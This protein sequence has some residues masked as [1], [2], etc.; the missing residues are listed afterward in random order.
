MWILCN[1]LGIIGIVATSL[2]E[3]ED[4][5]VYGF[6]AKHDNDSA[7]P[8]HMCV[9]SALVSLLLMLLLFCVNAD[10]LRHVSNGHLAAL[11][12]KG[13]DQFPENADRLVG[14]IDIWWIVRIL[15][16]MTTLHQLFLCYC[17]PASFQVVL[18]SCCTSV[19]MSIC[20]YDD[21]ADNDIS[22]LM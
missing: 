19:V 13:I 11:I 10:T 1:W 18:Y 22:N 6:L 3:G 21:Y 5:Y 2:T 16:I 15:E 17:I 14:T 4:S 12:A 7:Y 9:C 20:I 8:V